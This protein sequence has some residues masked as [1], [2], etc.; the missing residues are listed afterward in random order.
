MKKLWKVVSIDG[1]L[2]FTGTKKQCEIELIRLGK[3]YRIRRN[4]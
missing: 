3:S 2:I 4:Y 1:G